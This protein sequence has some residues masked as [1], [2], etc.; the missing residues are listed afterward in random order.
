MVEYPIVVL[1][2]TDARVAEVASGMF[3]IQTKRVNAMRE[4]Y[5]E[6]SWQIDTGSVQETLG[7][8]PGVHISW[9]LHLAIAAA[10]GSR[11]Q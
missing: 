10:A 2:S 4:G 5:W 9:I 1:S 7:R 11:P 8:L 3:Q 6:D